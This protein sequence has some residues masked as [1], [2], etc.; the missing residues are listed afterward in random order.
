MTTFQELSAF[1]TKKEGT[2]TK[3]KPIF[4]DTTETSKYVATVNSPVRQ[5]VHDGMHY[6]Q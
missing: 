5:H 3:D 1:L 4:Q 6:L 2:Q